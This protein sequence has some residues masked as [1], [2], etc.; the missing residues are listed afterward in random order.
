[1]AGKTKR[2]VLVLTED[3]RAMLKELSR[4]RTAPAREIE[5]AKVLIGYADGI[6]IAGLQRQTGGSRPMIYKCIDK[7]WPRVCKWD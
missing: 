6:S 3:Q 7:A 4:S 5:R 1:M 2:A